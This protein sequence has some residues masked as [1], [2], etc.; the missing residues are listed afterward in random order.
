M[1]VSF[2]PGLFVGL[3]KVFVCLLDNAYLGLRKEGDIVKTRS[4]FVIVLMKFEMSENGTKRVHI[5]H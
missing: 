5:S 1:V 2:S 3:V 4:V